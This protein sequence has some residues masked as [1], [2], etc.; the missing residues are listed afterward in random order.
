MP[1]LNLTANTK[2]EQK[3]KAYLEANSSSALA[4]KIN[5][6]VHIQKDGKTLLNKKTLA[7][8]MKFACDEAKKQAEKGA[9]SACIDDDVVYG[10][11][12]HYFEEED[13]EGTLYNEDGT[14]YKIQPSVT[15]KAPA[16]T[17]LPPKPQPKPQLSMFDLLDNSDNSDISAT[18]SK[19]EDEDIPEIEED[20]EPVQQT[21]QPEIKQ[22]V[23]AAEERQKAPGNPLYKTYMNI[24]NK[25]PDCIIAYHLGDFYEVFGENAKILAD[26]L[27][28]T[29]TGRDCGLESRVPMVGF[30]YHIT[31]AYVTKALQ[32][33][34]KI[35][36][37]ESLED[38]KT[39]CNQPDGTKQTVDLETGEIIPQIT[40]ADEPVPTVSNLLSDYTEESEANEQLEQKI[41]A[42]MEQPEQDEDDDFD[43][44]AFNTSGLALLYEKLGDD[45]TLR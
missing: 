22:V 34:L 15:A 13:I 30:P 11:A 33:G 28:L 5:N 35:A 25:Y 20:D 31:E 8:F 40:E 41:A 18:Q 27:D 7:G 29:L 17:Y 24:Q 12:V 16:V 44:E 45:I 23:K 38:I 21:M 19:D 1:E 3:I 9:Q 2:E 43:I 6:G 4:E 36:L 32:N 14:E 10:W 26:K 37:A 39:Y 42:V